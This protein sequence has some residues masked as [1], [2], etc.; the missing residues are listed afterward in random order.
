MPL[1]RPRAH[2]SRLNS[3]FPR[4]RMACEV[5]ALDENAHFLFETLFHFTFLNL[6]GTRV[7]QEPFH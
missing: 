5:R 4:V 6:E 3:F 2:I 1:E 7:L